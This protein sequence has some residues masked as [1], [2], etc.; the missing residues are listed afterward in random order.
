MIKSNQLDIVIVNWNSGTYLKKCLSSIA[1]CNRSGLKKIIVIDNGSTDKSISDLKKHK[2]P[3][4]LIKN[5]GNVGFSAACNQGVKECSSEFILFLNPDTRLFK[6]S[7]EKPINFLKKRDNKKIGIMGI[8]LVKND[9][10]VIRSC[11]RFP[12]L[13]QY[14]Y[15]LL[16]LSFLFPNSFKGHFMYEWN[17]QGNGRIVD[18]I[19]GAFFLTRRSLFDSLNG[20]DERFFVYYEEVDF[21]L[22]AL[23]KGFTSYYLTNA[24]AFHEGGGS[25]KN[26]R[27]TALFYSL[28]SRIL[29]A[30][31]NFNLLEAIILLLLTS[32]IEPITRLI[33]ILLFDRRKSI[34]DLFKTYLLLSFNMPSILIRA[35]GHSLK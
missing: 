3:L 27:S 24:R 35:A 11:A 9:G 7:L 21:S 30:F 5:F 15:K 22:R 12:S 10:T 16:G 33:N 26:V 25:S 1:N 29:Y 28:R 2:L 32:L 4:K 19:M 34:V 6:E 8:Q 31:K 20:F 17:H 13:K 14:L 18:Q 23:K